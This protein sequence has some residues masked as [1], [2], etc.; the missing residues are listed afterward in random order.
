MKEGRE[1]QEELDR[2]SNIKPLPSTLC[3]EIA[4]LEVLHGAAGESASAAD[5]GLLD[6][7][8]ESVE[9]RGVDSIQTELA[10]L[11]VSQEASSTQMDSQHPPQEKQKGALITGRKQLARVIAVQGGDSSTPTTA[12]HTLSES[13]ED[14]AVLGEMVTPVELV[15]TVSMQDTEVV[16]VQ[17]SD[18]ESVR[19]DGGVLYRL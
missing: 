7:T 16:T 11:S 18:D 13:D 1:A 8:I 3:K 2:N 5:I 6:S 14:M 17:S 15:S 10:N 9:N 12:I 19:T 4:D